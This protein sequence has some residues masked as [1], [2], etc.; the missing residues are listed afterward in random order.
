VRLSA[1]RSRDKRQ[2]PTNC[3][4]ERAACTSAG[5]TFCVNL[6]KDCTPH[7]ISG[8]SAVLALRLNRMRSPTRK[9]ARRPPAAPSGD[10]LRIDGDPDVL[11]C[12]ASP[13][14][15]RERMPPWISVAG[16]CMDLRPAGI[17]GRAD[18]PD[19]QY[20]ARRY[21]A[22]RPRLNWARPRCL[23][24]FALQAPALVMTEVGIVRAGARDLFQWR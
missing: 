9:L 8:D 1:L 15:G 13:M 20:G 17:A 23:Y 11:D 21:R 24:C 2:T 16:G 19:H 7:K 12:L 18:V 5:S 22:R 4:L 14:Q 3:Q 10:A 6:Q